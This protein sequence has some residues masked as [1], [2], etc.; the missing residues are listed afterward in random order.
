MIGEHFLLKDSFSFFSFVSGGIRV[1]IAGRD[2]VAITGRDFILSLSLSFNLIHN[3]RPPPNQKK[4]LKIH[5]L[6][7]YRFNAITLIY[8]LFY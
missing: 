4:V 6:F 1:F 2:G 7:R 3:I 8:F 5:W